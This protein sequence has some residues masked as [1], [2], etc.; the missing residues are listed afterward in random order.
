MPG[1]WL[2]SMMESGALPGRNPCTLAVRATR[3]SWACT[4]F[5]TSASETTTSTRRSR[6]D[7]FSTT[8]CI[9]N[10]FV[11]D[12]I[13]RLNPSFY[14]KPRHGNGENEGTLLQHPVVGGQT[15]VCVRRM[16]GAYFGPGRV[17]GRCRRETPIQTNPGANGE[18]RTLTPC[19]A[20]T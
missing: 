4:S 3:F 7:N 1:P 2:R 14:R 11:F 13:K 12:G 19:G 5:S 15:A 17:L 6:P 10:L 18:T 16:M 8:G 9:G 20:G